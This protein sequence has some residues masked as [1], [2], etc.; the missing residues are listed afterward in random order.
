M[1][2]NSLNDLFQLDLPL[3]IQ[4]FLIQRLYV[5]PKNWNDLPPG[6]SQHV[7]RALAP[8]LKSNGFIPRHDRAQF[9]QYNTHHLNL[10]KNPFMPQQDEDY[11]TFSNNR[12][13]KRLMLE[14]VVRLSQPSSCTSHMTSDSTT[15][16]YMGSISRAEPSSSRLYLPSTA[17]SS[18]PWF[19]SEGA[20]YLQTRAIIPSLS[21]MSFA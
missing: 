2:V 4:A 11:V 21:S 14:P 18:R 1:T 9:D 5:P 16:T 6:D 12:S 7:W 17:R 20:L 3:D 15:P 19:N 10:P 13:Q 8:L